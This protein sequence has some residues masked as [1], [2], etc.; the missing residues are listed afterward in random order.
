MNFTIFISPTSPY[1][2]VGLLASPHSIQ[3]KDQGGAQLLDYDIEFD[4]T[5]EVH[6]VT[7]DITWASRYD[8]YREDQGAPIIHWLSISNCF[9]ISIACTIMTAMILKR[10]IL[11]DIYKYKV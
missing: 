7:T 8:L 3:N 9:L 5:Y 2:V 11:S 10:S 4:V 1:R 6:F